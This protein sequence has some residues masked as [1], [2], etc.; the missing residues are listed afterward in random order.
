MAQPER[1]R[2]PFVVIPAIKEMH[3]PDGRRKI[4]QLPCSGDNFP[5]SFGDL[6]PDFYIARELYK[7]SQDYMIFDAPDAIVYGTRLDELNC[8]YSPDKKRALSASAAQIVNDTFGHRIAAFIAF[9]T[10]IAALV[11]P[12]TRGID[13]PTPLPN[14]A[15]LITPGVYGDDRAAVAQIMMPDG[16]AVRSAAL[17]SW[18]DANHSGEPRVQYLKPE[19]AGLRRQ[20][21]PWDVE[22]PS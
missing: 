16:S 20:K 19:R 1:I 18:A 4:W 22:I 5:A 11:D 12:H 10:A 17:D 15:Y 9:P 3:F 6:K 7:W 13:S 21:H 2:K 8:P 14:A